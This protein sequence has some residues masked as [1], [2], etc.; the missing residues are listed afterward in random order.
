MTLKPI[1]VLCFHSQV[2]DKI[3]K[4]TNKKKKKKKNDQNSILTMAYKDGE[5]GYQELT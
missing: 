3:H 1:T 2:S 5:S 4:K